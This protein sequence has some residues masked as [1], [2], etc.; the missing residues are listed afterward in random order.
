[1]TRVFLIGF[2]GAG[3]ST[4]GPP[5]AAR[6]GLPFLDLDHLIEEKEGRSIPQIFKEDGEPYFRAQEEAVLKQQSGSFL[7]S[8]GGGAFIT[9]GVRAYIKETGVSLFLDLPVDLLYARVAGD[10]NRPLAK[11]RDQFTALYNSRLPIYREA[12]VIWKNDALTAITP[13]EVVFQCESALTPVI[14]RT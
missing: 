1:M 9:P 6:L 5:L 11:D 4:I 8:L 7:L 14:T 12:E 2:M 13:E 10:E 3:K